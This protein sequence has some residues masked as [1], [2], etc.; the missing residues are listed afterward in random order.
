MRHLRKSTNAENFNFYDGEEERTKTR[1]CGLG[2]TRSPGICL[3]KTVICNMSWSKGATSWREEV[4]GRRSCR[5]FS[6][7][8]ILTRVADP[9]KSAKFFFKDRHVGFE[10]ILAVT[11]RLM[12]VSD[13]TPFSLIKYICFFPPPETSVQVNSTAGQS[14]R[15][16]KTVAFSFI[17]L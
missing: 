15:L 6:V 5:K 7:S 11:I 16:Q 9:L 14:A 4:S 10:V 8:L 1:N 2:A 17:W 3:R 12:P 13:M